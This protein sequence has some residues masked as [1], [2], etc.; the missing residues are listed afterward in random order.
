VVLVFSGGEKVLYECRVQLDPTPLKIS[1]TRLYV[2]PTRLVLDLQIPLSIELSEIMELKLDNFYGETFINVRYKRLTGISTMT[3]VCTGFG[4]IISNISKTRFV[5][6]LITRLREGMHPRD[7]RLMMPGP[8]LELY[9]PWVLLTVMIVAPAASMLFPLECWS[10]LVVGLLLL[11]SF[12]AFSNTEVY[13]LLLG[14][15]RRP[16]FAIVFTMLLGAL[17]I[18]AKRCLT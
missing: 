16:V 1:E 5:Y 8:T 6:T 18:I 17:V 11:A 3:F 15:I 2:T 14:R 12:T 7:A 4:G 13:R 10:R 9:A